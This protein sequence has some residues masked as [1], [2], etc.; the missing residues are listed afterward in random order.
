MVLREL[1]PDLVEDINIVNG[2]WIYGSHGVLSDF[3]LDGQCD[4]EC[5]GCR[6]LLE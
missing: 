3:C 2:Q 6:H 1:V 4:V 5:S